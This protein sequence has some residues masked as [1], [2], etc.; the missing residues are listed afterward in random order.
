MRKFIAGGLP[1]AAVLAAGLWWFLRPVHPD[2]ERRVLEWTRVESFTLTPPA[3]PVVANTPFRLPFTLKV[4]D[5]LTDSPFFD[6]R[7]VIAEMNAYFRPPGSRPQSWTDSTRIGNAVSLPGISPDRRSAEGE[8]TL[9]A[10][11]VP[12]EYEL[13]IQWR[14]YDREGRVVAEYWPD[15]MRYPVIARMNLTVVAGDTPGGP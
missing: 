13:R 7:M 3:E 15:G 4:E 6:P 1:A 8:L 5:P 14:E 2:A 11:E 10:P 9:D 12:G